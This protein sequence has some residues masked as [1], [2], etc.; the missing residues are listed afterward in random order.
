MSGNYLGVFIFLIQAFYW[1]MTL[2]V[3]I[4]SDYMWLVVLFGRSV[5][6]SNFIVS[7]NEQSGP[8]LIY[9]IANSSADLYNLGWMSVCFYLGCHPEYKGWGISICRWCFSVHC[10]QT[11]KNIESLNVWGHHK[12]IIKSLHTNK[13]INIYRPGKR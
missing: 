12:D 2:R 1:A 11:V 4:S 9:A 3:L 5:V 13:I 10:V 6:S 7:S 8:N